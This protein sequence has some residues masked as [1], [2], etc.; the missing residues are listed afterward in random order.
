MREQGGKIYSGDG[1]GDGCFSCSLSVQFAT[2]AVQ[3][4][5][6][7]GIA[8]QATFRLSEQ[9][10]LFACKLRTC[11]LEVSQGYTT[12]VCVCVRVCVSSPAAHQALSLINPYIQRVHKVV[13]TA[14]VCVLRTFRPTLPSI[15]ACSMCRQAVE[16][17]LFL[18]PPCVP[19]QFSEVPS[20]LDANLVFRNLIQ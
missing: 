8:S 16:T 9:L 11:S 14:R 17:R 19:K 20:Q 12:C 6:A 2:I 7:L 18:A 1:G 4:P 13:T 5:L 3:Q 15:N 10:D